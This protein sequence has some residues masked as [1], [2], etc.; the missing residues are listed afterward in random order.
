MK[1]FFKRGQQIANNVW[2]G[3]YF[4]PFLLVLC[5]LALFAD[6]NL[7]FMFLFIAIE[8]LLLIF[9][10]DL[11]S[12]IAPLF[13]ILLL[14]VKYFKD[15]SVLTGY[16][17]Y[18]IIPFAAAV[19]FNLIQYRKPLVKGKFFWPFAAVSVSLIIGGAG[20]VS[21]KEY[22]EPIALYY[23]LGLGIGMLALYLLAV[24]RLENKRPYNRAE[25]LAEIIY[26][27]G[28]LTSI[29]IAAFYISN[30]EEFI[31]KG[32]VLFFKARNYTTSV[33]LMALPMP[34]LFVKRN[35]I[36]IISMFVMYLAMVF[37]GSRSGLVF[38]AVLLLICLIYIL[39]LDNNHRAPT[40]LI[41]LT[42]I[43]FASFL[44]YQCLPQLFSSRLIGDKLITS[45]ET[46]IEYYEIASAN[47]LNHPILGMG[48]G[49]IKDI[50]VFKAYFPGCI[51]FYHNIIL[52]IISCLG[53]VGVASF[54]WMF[55][56]RIKTLFESRKKYAAVYGLSYLGILMMSMTNPGLFCPFP[57]TAL[58]MLMFVVLEKEPQNNKI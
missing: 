1:L 11:M 47:F 30:I 42:L 6:A 8:V 44:A 24:S 22:F 41:F 49:N 54:G 26:F 2:N 50:E 23:M 15:L 3:K 21:A 10:D 51:M 32:S 28:I 46:R 16:L 33:L 14:A 52:Q 37:S 34:C 43:V 25:R 48:V 19:I 4:L 18:A 40:F 9:C 58:V 57:E 13:C 31:K 56:K 17:W 29:I 35:K 38:G 39:T 5:V 7:E 12:I 55:V 45:D 53:I 27:S 36:H 20:V